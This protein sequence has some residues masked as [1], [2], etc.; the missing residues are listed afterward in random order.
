M[1]VS[2]TVLAALCL[3]LPCQA[4]VS[5]AL[6]KAPGPPAQAKAATPPVVHDK[7]AAAHH[8]QALS[9]P[10]AHEKAAVPP[11]HDKSPS[12]AAA[13]ISP[14]K[15]PVPAHG[16]SHA[17]ESW[18]GPGAPHG[19]SRYTS[20]ESSIRGLSRLFL[21]LFLG[22]DAEHV[23]R[24]FAFPFAG[25][26]SGFVPQLSQAVTNGHVFFFF[27]FS[28]FTLL[29]LPLLLTRCDRRSMLGTPA[30]PYFPPYLLNNPL[31]NGFPWGRYNKYTNYYRDYPKTGVIRRYEWTVSRGL[32]AADGYL[33]QVLQVNG[34]FPGPTI[35]ANWG[36]TIEVIVHND[37]RDPGE[38]V[39]FHWHGFL[40]E[41][42]PWEDGVPGVTEC[43]IPPG[44]SF[45]Y[46]FDAQLYGTTWWHS[47]YSAQ[48]A[49]GLFGAII[50]YGP[51]LV[52][53][54]FDA[55]PVL[56]SDYYHKDYF[57][58][59]EE[60][61]SPLTGGVFFS[62]NNLINGKMFFNCSLADE[63]N[64]PCNSNAGPAVF[65]FERGRTYR[66]RVINA[67]AEGLQRFSIDG[68]KLLVI[69][70]DF[71]PVEPYETTV[72]TL[73]IGQ[74][75]DVIVKADGPLD[76][77][78][79]RS[80]ISEICSLTSQP[81]ALAIINYV[82]RHRT[83][84]R[85]ARS[86]DSDV[87][88]GSISLANVNIP[89]SIPW[90]IPDPGTCANDPLAIT[91]PVMRLPV[92]KPDLV[93]VF[94]IDTFVNASGVT[95]WRFGGVSE[96]TDYNAPTLLLSNLGNYSFDPIWN[97][98]AAVDLTNVRR[99]GGDLS[100]LP[101]ARSVRIVVNNLSPVDHPMHLHGFNMQ[102]LNEGVG[103]WD[104]SIVRPQNPERRDVYM[105]QKNGYLAIQ[106][107]AIEN[108]ARC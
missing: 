17:D 16:V 51:E 50:I 23:V 67:G 107:N 90:N 44:A 102:I 104:G 12:K 14:N 4:A 59:V 45:T 40:Q 42:T 101:P 98:R 85:N 97:V 86:L 31:P 27:F 30:Q 9:P 47:H 100:A 37:I 38:G 62:D 26:H 8:H 63:D 20:S 43:P 64:R 75:Q 96:R 65:E 7:E 1:K 88:P 80:T 46:V 83:G 35:E 108:P 5:P 48:W 22:P 91:V 32:L 24:S 53:Y 60:T 3:I 52:P 103:R 36:D 95:L 87:Q 93:W 77:Y 89:N 66:L 82:D 69:A 54:D 55:G 25:F 79:M 19:L 2:R 71:V 74:R 105:L 56:I 106:F 92:I 41:G 18:V 81:Q 33:K 58:L 34:Q 11:A 15:Q 78:W 76:A 28:S 49:G 39:S 13:P 29:L 84:V 72:L 70:N 99:V 10:P 68:H 94:D 6:D 57:T 21:Q 61:L 73:G